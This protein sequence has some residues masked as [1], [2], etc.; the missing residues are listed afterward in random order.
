MKEVLKKWWFWLIILIV[1]VLTIS[2]IVNLI[3]KR[4]IKES[5]ENIGEGATDFIEGVENADSHSDEFEYN[6]TTDEVDYKPEVNIEKYNK[7]EEGMTE[8]E[9]I[10]ILGKYDNK[11]Q[12]EENYILEWGDSYSPIYGGYWIQVVFDETGKVTDKNQV[13]LD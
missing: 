6:H 3:N 10:L 7:I 9:I 1:A 11:L 12:G 2:I 4:K 8:E 13:G 5:A